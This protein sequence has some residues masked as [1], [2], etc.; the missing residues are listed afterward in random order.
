MFIFSL[1]ITTNN[2]IRPNMYQKRFISIL[3]FSHTK[4]TLNSYTTKRTLSFTHIEHF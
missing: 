2:G 1:E 4:W 3:D